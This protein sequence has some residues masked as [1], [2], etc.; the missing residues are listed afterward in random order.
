MPDAMIDFGAAVCQWLGLDAAQVHTLDVHLAAGKP[1]EITVGMWAYGLL[2]PADLAT[3]LEIAGH[4]WR[5]QPIE[6]ELEM[7]DDTGLGEAPGSRRSP[8][9]KAALCFKLVRVEPEAT[10]PQRAPTIAKG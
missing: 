9:G 5:L 3:P 1:P 2:P 7:I 6:G 8:I 4:R 10:M